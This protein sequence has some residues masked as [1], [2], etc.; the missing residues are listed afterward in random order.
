MRAALLAIAALAC[1]PPRAPAASRPASPNSD[2]PL[3]ERYTTGSRAPTTPAEQQLARRGAVLDP[4]L[5]CIARALAARAPERPDPAR[6]RHAL[7]VRCGSPLYPVRAQLV[8]DDAAL[9]AAVDAFER[10]APRTAPLALGVA[11]VAGQRVVVMAR[12]L[13]ELEPVPRIGA[14]KIAGRMLGRA[15]RGS[16][17]ISTARGVTITPF[18]F[19]DRGQ[20]VVDLAASRDATVELTFV[21][22]DGTGPFARLQLGGGS[23]L[24]RGDGSLLTR[25]NEARRVVGAAP[26][27]KLDAVGTCDAIPPQVAGNDVSDRARCFDVPLLDLDDLAD[28]IASRPLVQ[29]ILVTPAASLIEIGAAAA[30]EP[31]IRVRVLNRF[32]TMTPEAARQRVIDHYRLRWP[33]LVERRAEGLVKIL[34]AWARDPDIFASSATYKPAVDKLAAK[35]TKTKTYYGGLSTARDFEGALALFEPDQAPLAI[36]AALIQARG[37]DGAMLHLLAVVFEMP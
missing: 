2:P 30:P 9:L 6:F 25:I 3:A 4:A 12:T 28:E 27:A 17:M 19:R 33:Q 37:K 31:G 36:D 21:A 15:S 7:P 18:E 16:A 13:L 8:A 5:D 29:E 1:G 14:T 24:F 11:T 34:E 35:W 32:E 26:L 10:D 22:H 23:P 20:F